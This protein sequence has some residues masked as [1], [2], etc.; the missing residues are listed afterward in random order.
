MWREEISDE[1]WARLETLLPP[2]IGQGRPYLAHRPIVSGIVWVLRTGAPWRDV[3]ER[4][5]KWTTVS[6]RFRRW[7]AQ[8]IWQAI[9][10]ALQRRA[11]LQ[12]QL[13]WSMHFVDGTVVRAHQCAAGARGGQHNEALGRS[14]GG[15]S[16]KIHLRAE[17][18]GKPMAFVL[19]GGE[20]HE[21]KFLQP[22][23]ETG[24]VVR[25]R[26]GRPR[27][28]PDR[29]VGDKGYSYTT[30]RKYLH[31]RGIRVTIPRRKDQGPDICFDSAVYKERNKV[32]RLVGRL[33]QFRRIATRYDKR[34]LN[35]QGWLTV[36]AVLL[37]L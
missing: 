11:D 36:A 8:G 35:Y 22:L 19:S 16:T 21:S 6:S 10:A 24:A 5:G 15:F 31:H 28:R 29:L 20:R 9:W 7:T 3:P 12:G 14:R 18:H 27:I 13:D 17:G 32:E 37:W 26:Q 2:L 1:Q 30:V 23:L 33:K 4:F 34:A 25:A